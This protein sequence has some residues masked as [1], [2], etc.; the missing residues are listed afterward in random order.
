[1]HPPETRR[2]GRTA[3]GDTRA[4]EPRGTPAR[5]A[6]EGKPPS[7]SLGAGIGASMVRNSWQRAIDAPVGKNLGTRRVAPLDSRQGMRKVL[8]VLKPGNRL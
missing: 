3:H 6:D 8:F 1:M 2:T 7:P 4:T 5:V